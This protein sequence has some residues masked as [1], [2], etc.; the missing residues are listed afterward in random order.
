MIDCSILGDILDLFPDVTAA[1]DK[2]KAAKDDR[3]S[4]NIARRLTSEATLYSQF[5]SRISLLSNPPSIRNDGLQ[6]HVAE[7]L[8]PRRTELLTA[9]LN[10][11][12]RLLRALMADLANT[13]RGT[14]LLDKLGPRE[15]SARSNAPKTALQKRLDRL[16]KLNMD[17]ATYLLASQAVPLSFPG[18]PELATNVQSFFH[19]DRKKP[20]EAI[21][22]ITTAHNLKCDCQGPHLAGIRCACSKCNPGFEEPE[23]RTDEWAFEVAFQSAAEQNCSQTNTRL[24]EDAPLATLVTEGKLVNLS[25]SPL[26]LGAD[27]QIALPTSVAEGSTKTFM[28]LDD[29][30]R[31]HKPLLDQSK[32]MTLA[33]RLS[34]AVLQFIGTPWADEA[35]K[36][37]DWVVAT[38][39]VQNDEPPN[40]FIL[41][42]LH[43]NRDLAKATP[44]TESNWR[45]ASR[46]PTLVKLGLAL[47]ELALGRTLS[48]IRKE[49]PGFLNRKET[50][51]YDPELLDLFTAR[52][53]LSL[54][55]IAQTVSP[56]FQDVVSA[57]ITQQ[58]RDRRDAKIKELDTSD[59]FF[60]EYA[61][62]AI[63]MPLYQEAQKYLGDKA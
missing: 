11:M 60:L 50:E 13:R 12:Q 5:A 45:I 6:Q 61:T 4:R 22:A 55:Y 54:R 27:N 2:Y 32:R 15:P 47:V 46:E 42:N 7:W 38:D 30:S 23:P 19:H 49:E 14:E 29:L 26:S 21:Q 37:N 52:K 58:Y 16:S 43:T 24:A 63:L 31:S 18:Q 25:V 57:C 10:E 40:L 44:L 9:S 41:R 36:S 48:D 28:S 35:F 53:L 17:L 20:A 33:F 39:S 34:S 51:N 62:V 59:V 56:D 3:E 8:G 1:V